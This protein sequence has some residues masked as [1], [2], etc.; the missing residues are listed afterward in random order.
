MNKN[1]AELLI[2]PDCLPG[3]HGLKSRPRDS[4]GDEIMAGTLVCPACGRRYPV[5][6]GVAE[7][8]PQSHTKPGPVSKQ[9]ESEAVTAAYLW[10]HFADFMEDPLAGDAYAR[11]SDLLG[12]GAPL[13]L[14]VGCAV[15]RMTL[16]MG[17]RCNFTVG[18]DRSAAFVHAARRLA[19]KGR[20]DF[21]LPLE[22]DLK[23]EHRLILPEPLRSVPV[24]FI[25]A[26]ALALPFA[27]DSLALV[28][29]LNVV[30]KVPKP[31]QHLQETNRVSRRN[32]ARW[33]FSDP[34]SWS[35]DVAGEDQWLGGKENGEFAGRGKTNVLALL[36]GKGGHIRPAWRIETEGALWWK[37]R[38]HG[39]HYE[40]IRSEFIVAT[41]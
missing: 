5:H 12:D 20:I 23:T 33:L 27:A 30:D 39:N 9:Y 10:A 15:G 17:R 34:F 16:E 19:R 11:W 41:R 35:S 31:L 29:T 21:H 1:L 13:A 40:L 8:L 25:V 2:C 28:T 18:I 26:D 38:N 6:G 37:I 32:G 4:N 22:G 36:Q 3:E 24:E 7:I 14:D